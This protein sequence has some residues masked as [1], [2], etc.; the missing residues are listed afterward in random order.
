M[1]LKTC[2]KN[3][4]LWYD[5]A[6]ETSPDQ[7]CELFLRGVDP[8]KIIVNSIDED[9]KLYNAIEEIPL[10][11]EKESI[12]PLDFSWVIP[13]RYKSL[14]VHDVIIDRL[15]I[16]VK[17]VEESEQ[18]NYVNRVERELKE[19]NRRHLHDLFKTLIYVVDQ[20]REKNI[21]WGVGRGSSCASL[22]LFLLGV[23]LIDPVK[24]DI[25]MEEFFHD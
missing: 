21:V 13:E 2:L 1:E 14:S 5:G 24:F 7:A 9:V 20:L 22:C 16:F 12:A 6:V 3:R 10:S 17:N 4:V 18:L 15:Y 23:H 8:S 11:V 19:I 25:P